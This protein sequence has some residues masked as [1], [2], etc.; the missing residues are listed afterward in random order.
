ML[1]SIQLVLLIC[2]WWSF[3]KVFLFLAQE[4][5]VARFITKISNTTEFRSVRVTI[6]TMNSFKS[7]KYLCI[8]FPSAPPIPKRYIGFISLS[9]VTPKIYGFHFPQPHNMWVSLCSKLNTQNVPPPPPPPLYANAVLVS[10]PLAL[11]VPKFM[12]F[13]SKF[14]SVPQPNNMR[15]SLP[16]TLNTQKCT[17][18]SSLNTQVLYWFRLPQLW[19]DQNLW[20]SFPSAPWPNNMWVSLPSTL[21]TQNMSFPLL[22]SPL[23][24]Q[25]PYW[26]HLPQLCDYQNLLV[27]FPSAP[28]PNNIIL[29][30]FPFSQH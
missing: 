18:P 30:E 8:L 12:G 20:F 9:F 15:V 28:Q 23:N 14:P 17:S 26:F 29:C 10:F 6:F 5:V 21:D 27:S 16:S 22:G 1:A 7:P 19:D 2:S 4:L 13:I 11:T 3:T 24:T 25:A